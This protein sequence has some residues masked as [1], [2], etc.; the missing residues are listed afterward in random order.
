MGIFPDSLSSLRCLTL[1]S[2]DCLAQ[3]HQDLLRGHCPATD[4]G[5]AVL[6][7]SLTSGSPA[8]GGTDA[9]RRN[10]FPKESSPGGL[11]SAGRWDRE[12]GPAFLL[13][14]VYLISTVSRAGD[15]I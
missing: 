5:F 12:L 1:P 14:V 8:G 15:L 6:W 2:A 9:G 4:S 3:T 11:I 7:G 13:A 10:H